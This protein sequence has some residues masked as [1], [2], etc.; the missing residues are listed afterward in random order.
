[1]GVIK[2]ALLVS[3][4]RLFFI[5]FSKINRYQIAKVE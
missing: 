1:M 4:S 5:D 3:W 2:F